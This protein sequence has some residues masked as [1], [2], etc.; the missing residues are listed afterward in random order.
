MRLADG[1]HFAI[2][3]WGD[4]DDRAAGRSYI[5]R[6]LN[7]VVVPG[8]V[9]GDVQR[10]VNRWNLAGEVWRARQCWKRRKSAPACQWGSRPA[11]GR[12]LHGHSRTLRHEI[13]Q[14]SPHFDV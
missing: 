3:A 11:V 8:T 2:G 14:R 5:E 6:T 12:V 10:I 1:E 9:G 13:T 4:R 7:G